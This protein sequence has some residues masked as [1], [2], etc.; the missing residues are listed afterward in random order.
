M[1]RSKK[2]I[3]DTDGH[4]YAEID[5]E[6]IGETKKAVW[7]DD[8]DKKFPVPKSVMEDWPDVGETGTAMIKIWFAEKEGLI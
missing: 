1:L 3:K 2:L 8:G 4:E 7:F 6:N 5:V